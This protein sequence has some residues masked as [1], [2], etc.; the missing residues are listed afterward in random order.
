MNHKQV[1]LAALLML[2]LVQFSCS[3][4]LIDETL[5]W[6]TG[7]QWTCDDPHCETGHCQRPESGKIVNDPLT[8]AER[9]CLDGG[10]RWVC[11]DDDCASGHC[12]GQT[13]RTAEEQACIEAGDIYLWDDYENLIGHC[14][15]LAFLDA[16]AT[17]EP[18]SG[19]GEP[20]AEEAPAAG[21][22][23]GGGGGVQVGEPLDDCDARQLVVIESTLL[24]DT[25]QADG[26][27]WCEERVTISNPTDMELLFVKHLVISDTRYPDQGPTWSI[28]IVLPGSVREQVLGYH[29]L[30]DGGHYSWYQD[31][32]IVVFPS[33]F[34]GYD[35][36]ELPIEWLEPYA[37]DIPHSCPP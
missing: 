15:S 31:R 28:N 7:G 32:M 14:E 12:E 25:T 11:D 9:A 4:K 36:Y 34:A 5:C 13:Y 33:C 23:E 17:G 22:T 8:E 30:N 29:E 3:S 18:V 2:A 16:Y 19:D 1:V 26:R 24:F 10:G 21:G 20:A 6:N 27:R 37:F 35:L